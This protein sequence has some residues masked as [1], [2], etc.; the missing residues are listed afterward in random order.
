MT[1]N[2]ESSLAAMKDAETKLRTEWGADYN[3][4][5]ILAKRLVEKFGGK[6]GI[7]A[8]GDLGNNHNV[9]RVLAAIGK[10]M[11]EDAISHGEISDLATSTLDAKKRIEIINRQ[12][13]AMKGDEP[14]YQKILKERDELYKVAYPE[15]GSA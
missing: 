6:D 10:K 15:G 11:S 5:I 1:K 3:A 2:D 7:S 4:N 9:L 13:M 14:N 8:F 12:I